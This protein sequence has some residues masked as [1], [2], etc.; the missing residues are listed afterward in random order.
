[1]KTL[2]KGLDRALERYLFPNFP[3]QQA[4]TALKQ[5]HEP[6]MNMM[7]RSVGENFKKLE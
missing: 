4:V 6:S 5:S 1:M 7:V 3:L 2:I